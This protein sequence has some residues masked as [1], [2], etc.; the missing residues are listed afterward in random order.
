[1]VLLRPHT[2]SNIDFSR[3]QMML[4]AW[5]FLH[6]VPEVWKSS[7]LFL[8][9]GSG[10]SRSCCVVHPHIGALNRRKIVRKAMCEHESVGK[11]QAIFP[12]L[13]GYTRNIHIWPKIYL[14][15]IKFSIITS[16][17]K[18]EGSFSLFCPQR[19]GTHIFSSVLTYSECKV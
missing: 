19:K 13:L 1:M 3:I 7:S 17:L 2:C 16:A 15:C 11:T 4:N 12:L 6:S 10:N 5:C 14:S 8:G 9:K 18:S